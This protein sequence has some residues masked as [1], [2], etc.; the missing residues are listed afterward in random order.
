MYNEKNERVYSL[1]ASRLD[2]KRVD[3]GWNTGGGNDKENVREGEGE[4][5]KG[6]NSKGCLIN[7][8]D[9]W[10]V[11]STILTLVKFF[12]LSNKNL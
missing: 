11:R 3:E 5:S 2:F 12:S 9:V 8:R 7:K 4:N 6:E 10:R 1:S